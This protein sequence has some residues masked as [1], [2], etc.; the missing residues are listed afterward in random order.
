M[1]IILIEDNEHKRK[2]I[3]DFISNIDKSILIEE[4]YSYTSGLKKCLENAFD[5]LIIDMTMPTYDKSSSESGGRFR[6]YGG[7]EI[8]RQLKRK[9]KEIPFVVVSQYSKFSE[10]NETLSLEE[11]AEQL[12]T[13]SKEFY[14]DTVLYDTSSSNWKILL[15][16]ILTRE[17][18][19]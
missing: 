16:N 17:K 3:K 19:K 15:E 8:I 12:N 11:I 5:L 9:N 2:K 6:T 14:I 18:I 13:I 1:K 4:A 7:K 10:N